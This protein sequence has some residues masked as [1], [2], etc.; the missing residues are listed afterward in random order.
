MWAIGVQ[1]QYMVFLSYHFIRSPFVYLDDL[2]TIPFSLTGRRVSCFDYSWPP[3][4]SVPQS[5][6]SHLV[7]MLFDD[8]GLSDTFDSY[9]CW[10]CVHVACV[11][12]H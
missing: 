9:N 6:H 3:S 1:R 10:C 4:C 7:R 11:D 2:H 8:I 12:A 5:R